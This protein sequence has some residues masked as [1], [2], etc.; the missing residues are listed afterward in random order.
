ME[1]DSKSAVR[2]ACRDAAMTARFA[3]YELRY[4]ETQHGRAMRGARLP[5]STLYEPPPIV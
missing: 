5:R 3:G 2:A 1:R 4:G